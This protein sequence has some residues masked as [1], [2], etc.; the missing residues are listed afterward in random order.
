MQEGAA[1]QSGFIFNVR[2]WWENNFSYLG[3]YIKW[4]NISECFELVTRY[5]NRHCNLC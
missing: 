4:L 5:T 2:M 3:C 1:I